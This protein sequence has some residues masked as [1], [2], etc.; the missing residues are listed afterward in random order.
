MAL[1]DGNGFCVSRLIIHR[2]NNTESQIVVTILGGSFPLVPMFFQ[3]FDDAI[4]SPAIIVGYGQVNNIPI[5]NMIPV[6]NGKK[7][8]DA[9]NVL[10]QH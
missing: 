8:L 10:L 9:V 3:F 2:F 6:Q 5:T 7:K 1:F 4:C